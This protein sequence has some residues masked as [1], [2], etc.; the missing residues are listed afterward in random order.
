MYLNLFYHFSVAEK[1]KTF[2]NNHVP[3]LMFQ[4]ITHCFIDSILSWGGALSSIATPGENSGLFAVKLI[5][6]SWTPRGDHG[7]NQRSALFTSDSQSLL[8]WF[9]YRNVE[10]T[11]RTSDT[12]LLCSYWRKP[13][14]LLVLYSA[15]YMLVKWIHLIWSERG[16]A[17]LFW[18]SMVQYTF[19]THLFECLLC[20]RYRC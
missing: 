3:I 8:N 7:R 14:K 19:N 17:T 5:P 15:T 1:K 10:G 2:I 11:R 4:S 20:L 9:L 13:L 6:A 18:H 12:S 16:K